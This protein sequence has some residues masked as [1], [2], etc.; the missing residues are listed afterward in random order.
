M[1]KL[2]RHI[3]VIM[4]LPV[5]LHIAGIVV[6]YWRNGCSYRN[7]AREVGLHSNTVY[8]SSKDSV[9][10]EILFVEGIL[11]DHV[12]LMTGMTAFCIVLPWKPDDS[13]YRGRV[14]HGSQT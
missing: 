2:G 13:V 1:T 5:M 4:V 10:M 3:D 6:G 7:I 11:D 9:N 14:V 12:K 8:A